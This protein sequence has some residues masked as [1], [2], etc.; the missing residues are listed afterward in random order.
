MVWHLFP[1]ALP[2]A[3]ESIALLRSSSVG[4][5]YSS[6]ITGKLSRTHQSSSTNYTGDNKVDVYLKEPNT[7]SFEHKYVN[8]STVMTIITNLTNT[9]ICGFDGLSTTI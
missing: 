2:L 8:E 7:I 6:V 3:S 1:E 9:H 4:S 5:V